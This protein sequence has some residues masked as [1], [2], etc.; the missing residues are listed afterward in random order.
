MHLHTTENHCS[1]CSTRQKSVFCKLN[2]ESLEQID[3]FKHCT[4]YKKGQTI[5]QEGGYPIGLFCVSKGTIK[6]SQ[7]GSE[8]KEQIVRFAKDGDVLG[9]R[10]LLCGDRYSASAIPVE[11]TQICF[12]PREVFLKATVSDGGLSMEIIRKL[13]ED[14]RAA[15]EKITLLA[16]KPVRERMAETILFMKETFG[17][18]DDNQTLTVALSREEIANLVGTAT[19][20]AIRLLSEFKQDG[21]IEWAGKKL[22]IIN[23]AGLVK[24]ANLYD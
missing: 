15:Q 12:I 9:Y 19:E 4:S 23:L 22:R 21:Y 8:G 5:F 11:D 7:T 2:E 16:Q 18:E 24:T 13:A 3:Q 10:A 14:L 20:T 17:T 1:T 6:L